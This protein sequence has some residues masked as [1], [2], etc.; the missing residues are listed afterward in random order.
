VDIGLTGLVS[1]LGILVCFLIFV[2]RQRGPAQ[3]ENLA[4]ASVGVVSL[5]AVA[6]VDFPL[7]RPTEL[8]LFWTLLAIAFLAASGGAPATI[9]EKQDQRAQI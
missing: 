4:G 8:F 3:D 6:L 5:A 7:Q 1:F 2:L 9:R